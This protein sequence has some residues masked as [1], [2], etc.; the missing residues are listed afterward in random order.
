[1]PRVL[2]PGLQTSVVESGQLESVIEVL[3]VKN[4]ELLLTTDPANPDTARMKVVGG[5]ITTDEMRS[6]VGTGTA[7]LLM[8]EETAEAVL[9]LVQ[10]AGLSPT[11]PAQVHVMYRVKGE[12]AVCRY[13][14]YE[15]ERVVPTESSDGI[16]MTA[17][18]SDNSR[19]VQRAR[20]HRPTVVAQVGTPY[21]TAFHTL[22][23]KV[24]PQ[25]TIDVAPTTAKTGHLGFHSQEDRLE[26]VNK[27]ATAVGFRIDWNANG[28]GDVDIV[29]DADLDQPVTWSFEVPET[30][31]VVSST[32]ELTDERSYNGVI[33]FGENPNSG[34]PTVRGEVWDLDPSS[35]T[36]FDPADPEASAYGPVPFFFVSEFITTAKQALEAARA[37]LP[38]VIGLVEILTLSALPHPGIVPGDLILVNRPRIGVSGVF[39][40]E[41]VV[42]PLLGSGG[43]MT[44]KCRE[45]R[46]FV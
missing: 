37:R 44:V 7:E 33:V 22:L 19:R 27:L 28:R 34:K 21:A 1:M 42:M 14:V 5:S 2:T 35:P 46:V 18:V 32:R 24:L 36:Y 16:T 43:R 3:D 45:R 41:S 30:A 12:E 25:A 6:V 17:E 20:F 10:G 38:K 15:V 39:V 31:R 13:G 29:P 4:G 40:V 23:D 8:D 11:A 26:A 9:P